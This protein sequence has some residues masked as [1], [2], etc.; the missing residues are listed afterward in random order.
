MTHPLS[1]RASLITRPTHS[2]S[3]PDPPIPP[4]RSARP[5][6]GAQPILASQF[7]TPKKNFCLKQSLSLSRLNN[8]SHSPPPPQKKNCLNAQPILVCLGA[9][10]ISDGGRGGFEI[11]VGGWLTALGQKKKQKK[12]PITTKR[13]IGWGGS[14]TNNNLRSPFSLQFDPAPRRGEPHVTRRTPDYFL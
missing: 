8:H 2:S 6:G 9:H 5:V 3:C 13:D 7:K 4:G 12:K 11:W 10:S 1:P 14:P